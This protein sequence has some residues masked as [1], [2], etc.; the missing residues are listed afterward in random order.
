M[1]TFFYYKV[2]PPK[3]SSV[4]RYTGN[5]NKMPYLY[6]IK[7]FVHNYAFIPNKI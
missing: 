1:I 4:G 6:L 2:F 7:E 5:K 3:M